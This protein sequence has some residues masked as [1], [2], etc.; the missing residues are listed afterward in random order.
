[1]LQ[2]SNKSQ[3]CKIALGIQTQNTIEVQT[4]KYLKVV[5]PILIN[6]YRKESYPLNLKVRSPSE[7]DP[8]KNKHIMNERGHQ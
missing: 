7:S 2:G 4:Q 3:L 5:T 8:S 6:V 1:M